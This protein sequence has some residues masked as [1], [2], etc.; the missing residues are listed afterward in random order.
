MLSNYYTLK[1][2]AETAAPL[3]TGG[4]LT[5][6]FT[7][8][9]D[10]LVISFE[11]PSP[12]LVI[13]CHPNASTCYLH[14]GIARARRNSMDIMQ[15]C[16]G[17]RLIGLS[18]AP[19]DRIIQVTLKDGRLLAARLFGPKSNVLLIE[20]GT[21]INAFK[22][23][24]ELP[25][26]K[27]V[28]PEEEII[29]D[30]A[31]FHLSL[32]ENAPSLLSA[33]FRSCFPVLGSTVTREVLYRAGLPFSAKASEATGNARIMVEQT[34][35]A[36]L[37]ELHHP[38][39]RVYG[40][41]GEPELFSIIPLHHV[42]EFEE[43]IFDNVHEAVRYFLSRRRAASQVSDKKGSLTGTLRQRIEKARRT[44]EAL[45]KEEAEGSRAEG[46]EQA[47]TLLMA[48]LPLLH[49]GDK[50]I[51][52]EGET[53]SL[54]PKLAPVQN[55]QRYFERAKRS[56]LAAQQ[57]V[58]RLETLRSEITLGEQLLSELEDVTTREEVKRFMEDYAEELDRFG[59]GEKSEKHRELPFR[60]F[61]VDG[62]FEVWAGKSSENNDLLTL[63]HAKPNDLWF[64]ARGSSG[65]H[66]VL[67]MG[68]GKGEPG[69][70]AKEQAAGIAAYYSKMK[71]ARMV[72]VAMTEKKYVRKPKGAPPGTVVLEREKVLF[73]EPGLPKAKE[74]GSVE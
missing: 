41:E 16:L 24:R 42:P 20:N 15:E 46:Y 66:V 52:I 56:R 23:A 68:T 60:I 65:S 39:A 58:A 12:S 14:G 40:R 31:R 51:V 74:S 64:H 45:R 30:F 10:E 13:C 28:A 53:I 47:G 7:Q 62:G 29:F 43:R 21:V 17:A 2:L 49:K 72:P 11:P 9:K 35:R 8:V 38:E 22:H 19:G 63:H 67:K 69:K 25:G 61:T 32:E 55:A 3:L 73:A 26:S 71:N 50:N 44:A 70:K 4:V 1:Y 27:Y 37:S 48:H 5:G 59:I 36:I 54:D 18:M 57:S 33:V 6:M 34:I